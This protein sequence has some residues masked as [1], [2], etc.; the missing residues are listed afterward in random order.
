[1]KGP[2]NEIQAWTHTGHTTCNLF[3]CTT[4]KADTCST[5][6]VLPAVMEHKGSTPCSQKF[7]TRLYSEPAVPSPHL[8]IIFL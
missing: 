4:L 8:Q 6:Q 5:G 2:P 7:A 3:H 1:M